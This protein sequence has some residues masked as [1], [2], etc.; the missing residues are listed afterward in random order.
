M[1]FRVHFVADLA[2]DTATKGATSEDGLA[3]VNATVGG[4]SRSRKENAGANSHQA[5]GARYVATVHCGDGRLEP[6]HTTVREGRVNSL[7][8][9]DSLTVAGRGAPLQ[10]AGPE[11]SFILSQQGL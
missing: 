11:R 8:G 3:T 5:D 4:G 1:N 6:H 2:S 10:R 7:G 9:V